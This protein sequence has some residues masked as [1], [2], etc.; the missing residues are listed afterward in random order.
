MSTFDQTC[1]EA[2]ELMTGYLDGTLRATQRWKLERHLRN[3]PHCSTYLK[4]I[5]QV[6]DAVGQVQP[7]DLDPHV[8]AGVMDLYR[9]YLDDPTEPG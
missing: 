6:A 1:R 8:R 5:R 7:D 3:C 2:V 9:R 4:Q